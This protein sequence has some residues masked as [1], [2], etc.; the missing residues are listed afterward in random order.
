MVGQ[1]PDLC[2]PLVIRTL[3]GERFSV[4]CPSAAGPP[5]PPERESHIPCEPTPIVR[6]KE[7]RPQIRAAA[8]KSKTRNMFKKHPAEYIC[9]K[10][11]FKGQKLLFQS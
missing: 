8:F 11:A 4:G 5:L 2:L 3:P 10:V 7:L 6:T 1:Q 9:L